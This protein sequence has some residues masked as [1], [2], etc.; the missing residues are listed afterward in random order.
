M[1]REPHADGQ[2]DCRAEDDNAEAGRRLDD[3]VIEGHPPG[4]RRAGRR[5]VV[6]VLEL[7]VRH[8]LRLGVPG[9]LAI[10]CLGVRLLAVSLLA[11]GAPP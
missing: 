6:H 4:I 11:V 7:V 5:L 9:L 10:G 8:A 3:H 2:G 1:R